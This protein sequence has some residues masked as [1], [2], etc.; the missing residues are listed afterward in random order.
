VVFYSGLIILDIIEKSELDAATKYAKQ[1]YEQFGTSYTPQDW[2]QLAETVK[3]NR[4]A[5]AM[6]LTLLYVLIYF[7]FKLVRV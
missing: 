7:T 3:T 5:T 2:R 1:V 6:L 4:T